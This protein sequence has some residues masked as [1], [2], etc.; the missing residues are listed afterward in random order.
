MTSQ[1]AT[2]HPPSPPSFVNKVNLVSTKDSKIQNVSVYSG[3]AEVTRLFKVAVKTGQNQI[4]MNGLPNGLDWDSVRV[5]GRG[6]A[7]I[8]DVTVGTMPTAPAPTTSPALDELKKRK[9][10][11][12]KSLERC[13]RMH[14]ALSTYISTLHVQHAPVTEL[15]KIVEG[16]C[17]TGEKLDHKILD[18]EAELRVI[19]KDIEEEQEKLD[20]EWHA[21]QNESSDDDGDSQKDK[22]HLLRQK[23]SMGVFVDAEG[24]VELV[25][26]YAVI[27]ATWDAFYD[28]RVDTQT[29]ETPVTIVYKAAI[30]QNSGESWKDIQLTLETATPTFGVDI[31]ILHPWRLSSHPP[32]SLQRR[33]LKASVFATP[34]PPA[35]AAGA[36]F[37]RTSSALM[38]DSFQ[39]TVVAPIQVRQTTISSRGN[40]SATFGVPGIIT[41]PSDGSAHNVTI[42]QLK[43]DAVM[44]W[45]AVPKVDSKVRLNAKVKNASEYTL[46][47]GTAS[48]YVDGSFISKSSVPSVSP[49]ESFD[50]PL[51]IDP[52]VRIS[53]HPLTKKTTQS[54]FGFFSQSRITSYTQA[55]S[56]HNT[57]QS[58]ISNL[59]IVDQ[60]PI[61]ED[62]AIKVKL[63]APVLPDLLSAEGGDKS[64]R[65][66]STIASS[67]S[68]LV[69]IKQ[70]K[71]AD[72][73]FA[74][75]G[76]GQDDDDDD[77]THVGKDGKMSWLCEVGSQRK[78]TLVMQWEISVPARTAVYGL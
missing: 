43:L 77:A 20:P 66:A 54:S 33:A 62:D 49:D 71:V 14:G 74:Q 45:I 25:L 67:K 41:I 53:Y 1:P 56:A 68:S 63:L 46:I 78:I 61:S 65:K 48:I 52:S 6:A 30:T 72:G 32:P 34:P 59:R 27:G 29:K 23:V 3:R 55:I 39:K 10:R 38:E 24:E 40:V 4:T 5:E 42:T 37:G 8:H 19:E 21:L 18:L 57:K 47:N 51:G 64:A 50:C 31:P 35:P 9:E 16:Y 69:A 44:S 75:W 76:D 73:V 11:S 12:T 13:K 17:T 36:A 28:V 15:D 58:S 22:P 7:T 60:F 2:E 26:I 70:V